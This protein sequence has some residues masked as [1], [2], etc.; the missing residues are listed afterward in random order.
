ME[1]T[2]TTKTRQ[3]IE[4]E[5]LKYQDEP[6]Y[7]VDDKE[8]QK[9]PFPPTFW[10]QWG[11]LFLVGFYFIGLFLN[12]FSPLRSYGIDE[13]T[14]QNQ[15]FIVSDNEKLFY[16]ALLVLLPCAVLLT[17]FAERYLKNGVIDRLRALTEPKNAR[18]IVA[19]LMVLSALLILFIT[20]SVLQQTP[21]S[22]DENVYLF[23]TRIMSHGS[24]TLNSKPGDDALFEDNIFLVNNDKVYGQY[25]FGHSA[26][27]LIGYLLG[28]PY[29]TQLLFAVMTVL[30]AYLLGKELY[31]VSEGL[32]I[33][34]LVALSP[35]F[36][37]TS[38]T[39]L[40]HT[41]TLFF[42]TWFG[43]FALKTVRS[44]SKLVYPILAGLTFGA[45]F[46]IRGATTLLIG[47]PAALLLAVTLLRHPKQNLV[48]IIACGSTVAAL[49]GLFLFLNWK[50]N[51]DPFHTNYHAA[52]IGKTQFDSPF[53]FGKGAWR[54][55][56]TPT[57]G[58]WNAVNNFIKLDAWV[59]GWPIG[60]LFVIVWAIRKDRRL[61]D[62]LA[63]IPIL[64]TFVAYFFYFWPGI[65]DTG[66]VLYFELLLPVA[67]LTARGILKA[68]G[69]LTRFMDL[70][71]AQ[72]RVA[73]FVAFS[74]ILALVTFHYYNLKALGELPSKVNEPYDSV[75]VPADEKALIFT[76]YYFR[77]TGQTSWVAGHKNTHPE[78]GDNHIFVLDFGRTKDEAFAEKYYPDYKAYVFHYRNGKPVTMPLSEYEVKNYL[79]NYPDSR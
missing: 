77:E 17:L 12:G 39:L 10:L 7:Y 30:G 33:S 36:L 61:F 34:G 27:L 14:G 56:H 60:F 76:D 51:G 63:L 22:D 5:K 15:I 6:F 49:V 62:F 50:V 66:P 31:G 74:M 52:W 41:N 75:A 68:P 72:K 2:K 24:L 16:A 8:A 32:L 1:D 40:S 28:Y 78:L 13:A 9:R 35:S 53:G 59:F 23:Q 42:L 71:M 79:K 45:A 47:M 20:T 11:L 4:A 43:Y 54:I 69:L 3:E 44:E 18:K 19:G 26:V 64:L 57:Q 58:L 70:A 67:I 55:M 38:S 29:L 25:P 21:I 65:S 48:K 73:F 37:M 46:H